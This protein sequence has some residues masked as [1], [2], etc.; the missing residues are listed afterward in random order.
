MREIREA[1]EW[2][3]E[4]ATAKEPSDADGLEEMIGTILDCTPK[5]PDKAI[6]F[7]GIEI[8]VTEDDRIGFAYHTKIDKKKFAWVL[9]EVADEIEAKEK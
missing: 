9:R 3:R 7:G 6:E 5:T 8:Y 2:I 1:A 4:K